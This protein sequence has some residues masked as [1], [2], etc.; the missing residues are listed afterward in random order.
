M[1]KILLCKRAVIELVINQHKRMF[2]KSVVVYQI[3]FHPTLTLPDVLGRELNCL[4]SPQ[5]IRGIKG[6]KNVIKTT[7]NH[8]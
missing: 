2:K 5:D 1:D 3:F 8:F 4:V 7:V 6:S